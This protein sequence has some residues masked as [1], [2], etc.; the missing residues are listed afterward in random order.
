MI[1]CKNCGNHFEGH[2]CNLCGQSA[3]TDR[4][5]TEFIWEDIEHG[6]LHYDKGIWYSLKQLFLQPGHSIRDYIE[7]KR[8]KHFRPLSMLIVLATIYALIYHLTDINLL[9]KTDE[10]SAGILENIFHHYYWYVVATIPIY[11]ISTFLMFKNSGYNYSELFVFEA[12]KGSQRMLIH[13]FS[14]PVIYFTSNPS[15]ASKINLTLILIDFFLILWS[16][17]QFFKTF[18]RITTII[19]SI[20]SFIIYLLILLLF[21]ILYGFITDL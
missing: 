3:K 6:L 4:I 8:V 7:G 13:I 17:I 12:F 21:I 20:I 16:N 10:K 14:I 18:P 1:I 15:T 2:Y 11:T 19:R 5:T 9:T